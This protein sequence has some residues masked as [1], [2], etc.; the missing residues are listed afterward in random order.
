MFNWC[1][2]NPL[3]GT[4]LELDSREMIALEAY[5]HYERRGVEL[6]PGKH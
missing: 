6:E 1:L 2:I 3:E 4:E 5:V